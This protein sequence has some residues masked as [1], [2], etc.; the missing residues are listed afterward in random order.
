MEASQRHRTH[1]SRANRGTRPPI[2]FAA[3][4]AEAER[5]KAKAV[6]VL[7]ADG[8]HA[9]VLILFTEAGMQVAGLRL[10]GDRPMHE[11]VKAVV[12]ARKAQAFVCISEAWAVI[13]R[14]AAEGIPPSQHPE[15]RQV[16]AVS[17]VHPEGTRLWCLP[18]ASEGGMVV[19]SPALDTSGMTLGGGIPEALSGEESER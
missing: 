7:R 3:F 2:P 9:P 8:S 16:L 10:E 1:S 11:I 5:L 13:G 14:G 15:R 18:F 6:E 17:A 12:K 19:V 4:L